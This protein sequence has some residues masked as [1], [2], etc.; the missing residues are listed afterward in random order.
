MA[1]RVIVA[2]VA[3][4]GAGLLSPGTALAC[5]VCFGQTDSPLAAGVNWGILLL[6]GVLGGVLFG[7]VS[8]FVYLFKRS[9]ALIGEDF[10]R[11]HPGHGGT[12]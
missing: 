2:F 1:R 10:A 7:F 4:V 8:F 5:P 12:Y 11:P 3:L 9:R 6:L